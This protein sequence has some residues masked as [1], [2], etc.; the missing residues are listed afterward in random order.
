MKRLNIIKDNVVI[1]SFEGESLEAIHLQPEYLNR[2]NHVP[3]PFG[4]A[5]YSYEELVSEAIPEIK[6]VIDEVEVVTQEYVPAV[7]QTIHVLA[8]YQEELV[9][10]TSEIEQAEISRQIE[11][12]EKQITPRRYREAILSG[13]NSFIESIETQV[14]VLR[15]QL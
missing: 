3:C 12:L 8:E 2:I 4:K 6:E 15:E 5:A 9:D 11:E 7:Y 13:D 10:I 1:H 14:Q